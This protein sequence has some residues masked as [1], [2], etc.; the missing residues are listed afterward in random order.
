MEVDAYM[1]TRVTQHVLFAYVT[2]HGC[3]ILTLHLLFIFISRTVLW[4]VWSTTP[5]YKL[6]FSNQKRT[7]C[8]TDTALTKSFIPA[9]DPVISKSI[10][11]LQRFLVKADDGKLDTWRS[12]ALQ[13]STED[14]TGKKSGHRE[15]VRDHRQRW[16]FRENW[17][18]IRGT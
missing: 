8:S 18:A 14:I 2:K 15:E 4:N 1:N 13:L 12:T 5:C 7:F 17:D 10:D 11:H 3:F 6:V 9:R 16:L